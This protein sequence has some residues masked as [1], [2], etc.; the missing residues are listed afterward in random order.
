MTSAQLRELADKIEAY[1]PRTYSKAIS[2]GLEIAAYM[3]RKAAGKQAL[4]ELGNR[5]RC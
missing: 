2:E 3:V 1:G 5:L 4:N